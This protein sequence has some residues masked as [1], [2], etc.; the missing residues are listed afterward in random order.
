M[1]DCDAH[2]LPARFEQLRAWE[3]ELRQREEVLQRRERELA[4]REE[5]LVVPGV[6]QRQEFLHLEQRIRN[7]RRR[8]LALTE[9][10]ERLRSKLAQL[11][12]TYAPLDSSSTGSP[13]QS[14][15]HVISTMDVSTAHASDGD[16]PKTDPTARLQDR[17]YQESITCVAHLAAELLDRATEL[18]Q[19]FA[20][21]VELRSRWS[22]EWDAALRELSERQAQL[23]RWQVE[24]AHRQARLEEAEAEYRRRAEDQHCRELRLQAAETRCSARLRACQQAFAHI[25]ARWR[26]A[27]HALRQ[28]E[29]RL[30]WL[31]DDC[32]ALRQR[33]FAHWQRLHRQAEDSIHRYA[34]LAHQLQQQFADLEL[35][36]YQ[37]WQKQ[38]G[39]ELA[40]N[41]WAVQTSDPAAA[42]DFVQQ[43]E[44][45]LA[46]RLADWQRRL[47]DRERLLTQDRLALQQFAQQLFRQQQQLESARRQFHEQKLADQ[48]HVYC[49]WAT[50]QRDLAFTEIAR[51]DRFTLYCHNDQLIQD[52]EHLAACFLSESSSSSVL[53]R[54]A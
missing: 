51:H 3:E 33:E 31:L 4:E 5:R 18:R 7:A 1:S 15:T 44:Q 30:Q 39:L 35:A 49:Q 16:M 53:S 41:L 13:G 8:L 48:W 50:C 28:R 36:R 27:T 43:C 20:L 2:D 32:Q 9:E 46:K 29:L 17:W 42:E 6:P 40:I 24:L 10:Y 25:K 26:A 23:E 12:P 34:A 22:G 45:R 37:L 54:A 11:S 21:L 14:V 38:Q 47:E 52:V 19:L